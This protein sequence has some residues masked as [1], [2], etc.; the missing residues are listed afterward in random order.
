MFFNGRVENASLLSYRRNYNCLSRKLYLV[1]DAAAQQPG[2]N[3]VS[4]DGA[5]DRPPPPKL[6]THTPE[7]KQSAH[8]TSEEGGWNQT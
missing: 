2:H 8:S 1:A 6:S 4:P 7:K 3:A 5:D